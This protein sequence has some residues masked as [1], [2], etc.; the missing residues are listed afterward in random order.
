MFPV[1]KRA[2]HCQ[3]YPFQTAL[4]W[5]QDCKARQQNARLALRELPSEIEEMIMQLTYDF[6][7]RS[8]FK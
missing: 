5:Y 3:D 7:L 8:L 4:E 2:R 6:L 1:K